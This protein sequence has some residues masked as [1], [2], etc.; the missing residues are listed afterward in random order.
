RYRN[1]LAAVT[2]SIGGTTAQVDYAG[3]APGF[4]GLD[5]LNVRLPRSRSGVAR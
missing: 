5:Q 3:S 1:S 4:V 2:A